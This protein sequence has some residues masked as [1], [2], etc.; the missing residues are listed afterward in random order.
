[1]KRIIA[2]F[3]LSL[4][5]FNLPASAEMQF[6]LSADSETVFG[7]EQELKANE[8]IKLI[9]LDGDVEINNIDFDDPADVASKILYFNV[10]TPNEDGSAVGAA[11]DFSAFDDKKIYKVFAIPTFSSNNHTVSDFSDSYEEICYARLTDRVQYAE[12]I[13]AALGVSSEQVETELCGKGIYLGIDYELY[14]SVSAAKVADIMFSDKDRIDLGTLDINSLATYIDDSVLIV[15]LN[16]GNSGK[17]TADYISGLICSDARYSDI[18]DIFLNIPP[19]KRTNI[20]ADISNKNFGKYGELKQQ[21]KNSVVLN[22]FNYTDTNAGNLYKIISDF[23][24][25][26]SPNI[27]LTNLAKMGSAARSNAIIKLVGKKYAT[28]T[29]LKDAI[30]NITVKDTM[31]NTPTGGGGGGGGGGS[32][33]VPAG[34]MAMGIT[35]FSDMAEYKWAENALYYLAQKKVISGYGDGTFRPQNNITRAEFVKIVVSCFFDENSEFEISFK[36]VDKGKWYGKYIAAAVENKLVSGL[37]DT[38]FGPER[39]ITRQDMA[40]ILYNTAQIIDFD[41]DTEKATIADD[42]DISEYAKAAVYALKN[43]GVINGYEDGSVRPQ[44]NANRAET[45]QM[46]YSFLI[47]KGEF[48]DEE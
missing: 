9:V 35:P 48:A 42:E 8:A 4:L 34:D 39:Y 18:K 47:K 29:Q 33:S 16:G 2:F 46:V 22:A 14:K 5:A 3:L 41:I 32:I 6:R 26:V 11:I 19:E 15:I 7:T 28:I 1:M 40:V 37:S 38:E 43:A 21:I 44:N 13:K 36:D 45:V 30:D 20:L 17:I 12:D 23:S 10:I 25:T 31:L 27:N 24:N